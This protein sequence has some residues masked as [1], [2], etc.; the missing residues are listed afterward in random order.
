M[1]RG[2]ER[3]EA[4]WGEWEENRSDEE[5][6]GGGEGGVRAGFGHSPSGVPRTYDVTITTSQRTGRSGL[7]YQGELEGLMPSRISAAIRV[8]QKS[9]VLP[10]RIW[11]L[12][13]KVK[14]A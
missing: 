13:F 7:R 10:L 12:R 9:R 3:F 14:N 1:G 6:L 2:I 8:D 5:G 11:G 4:R